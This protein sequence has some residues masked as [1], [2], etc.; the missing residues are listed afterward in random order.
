MED[1]GEEQLIA[2][3]EKIGGGEERGEKQGEETGEERKKGE[4]S[5]R[6]N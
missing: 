4:E 2:E 1:N 5:R 6:G 3:L